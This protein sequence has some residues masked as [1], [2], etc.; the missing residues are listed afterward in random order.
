MKRD[1]V[2]EFF[3][4][5]RDCGEDMSIVYG[6]KRGTSP[7]SEPRWFLLP[8]DKFD[9]MSGLGHLLREQGSPV[10]S[11]PVLRGDR[12]SV[13]RAVRGLFAVLPVLGV[14]RRQWRK[15]DGSRQVGFLPAQERVAWKLFTVEQTQ[16]IIAAAQAER[17]T[18]NTYLLYHLDAVVANSALS[19]AASRRWMI[20]VNLR[21]AVTREREDSPHMSFLAVDVHGDT[22]PRRIQSQITRLKER[23]CHWGSWVALHIGRLVGAEAMRRDIRNREKKQHGW[24]GIFSN[25]GVWK[26]PD[27][28]SWVFCPAIA[29]SY[30]VG[31]GCVTINGRM[32][33]TLQLHD[34]FDENLQTTRKLLEA[35]AEASLQEPVREP[36]SS[37]ELALGATG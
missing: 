22:S 19:S 13:L 25:L 27:S 9:G 12:F 2:A 33:L 14:M 30:P 31:A 6:E 32:S 35:W 1:W 7:H 28:G 10:D 17:V 5:M 37:R 29:R 3:C 24:T 16:A 20:P 18:V 4:A 8:H 15:F 23:A 26:V 34:G 11:L 36:A 21:G